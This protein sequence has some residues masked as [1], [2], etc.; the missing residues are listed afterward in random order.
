MGGLREPAPRQLPEM[1][2]VVG[3]GF[4]GTRTVVVVPLTNVLH[5]TTLEASG[6]G[7]QHWGGG[8]RGAP[9]RTG[10]WGKHHGGG[11]VGGGGLAGVYADRTLT[12]FTRWPGSQSRCDGTRTTVSTASRGRRMPSKAERTRF[13]SACRIWGPVHPTV[14]KQSRVPKRGVRVWALGGSQATSQRAL[15]LPPSHPPP[16]PVS[17]PLSSFPTR[18]SSPPPPP[19]PPPR[20]CTTYGVVQGPQLNGVGV[21]HARVPSGSVL[22]SGLGGA[23]G[24]LQIHDAGLVLT[25]YLQ[26]LPKLFPHRNQLGRGGGGGGEFRAWGC[27]QGQRR[28]TQ[29]NHTQFVPRAGACSARTHRARH[30]PCFPAHRTLHRTRAAN[31]TQTSCTMRWFCVRSWPTLSSLPARSSSNSFCSSSFWAPSCLKDAG[32][33]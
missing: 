11:G 30:V 22:E 10:R 33:M 20:T 29:R 5:K 2:L 7:R 17:T 23:G 32:G 9:V 19:L 12:P 21:H 25:Q 14:I 24:R 3:T 16:C 8:G 26:G 4:K 6:L 13:A 31:R 27:T 1:R 15:V 28:T 18:S